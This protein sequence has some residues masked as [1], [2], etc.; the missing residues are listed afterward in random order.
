MTACIGRRRSIPYSNAVTVSRVASYHGRL[1][2]RRGAPTPRRFQI[3][4]PRRLV[5]ADGHSP[6]RR[7]SQARW[8][9][10]NHSQIVANEDEK[11][12]IQTMLDVPQ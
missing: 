9:T 5:A 10:G 11:G 12:N 3:L 4:W 1:R 2:S 6:Q 7:G 8:L